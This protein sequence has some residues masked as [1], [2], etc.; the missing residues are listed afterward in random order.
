L[1]LGK[2]ALSLEHYDVDVIDAVLEHVYAET[3]AGRQIVS[4]ADGRVVIR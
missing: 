4:Q 1:Y 3:A 2:D